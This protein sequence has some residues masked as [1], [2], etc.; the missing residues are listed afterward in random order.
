MVVV[1]TYTSGRHSI[2]TGGRAPPCLPPAPTRSR[3]EKLPVRHEVARFEWTH[4]EEVGGVD[5]V[6]PG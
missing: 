2:A 1:W 5:C 6:V 4:R 3:R